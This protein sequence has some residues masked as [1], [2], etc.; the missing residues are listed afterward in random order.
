MNVNR[1]IRQGYN[2]SPKRENFIEGKMMKKLRILHVIWVTEKKSRERQTPSPGSLPIKRITYFNQRVTS[3]REA[4]G[5][6]AEFERI[7]G[8]KKPGGLGRA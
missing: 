7:Q 3:W 6:L 2:K 1:L 4:G 5:K 8:V